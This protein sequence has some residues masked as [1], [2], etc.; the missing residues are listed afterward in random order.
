MFAQHYTSYKK[1]GKSQ[2]QKSMDASHGQLAPL[3][4]LFSYTSYKKAGKSQL[5]KSMDTSHGQEAA[6]GCSSVT[7]LSGSSGTFSSL[8]YPS[9]YEDNKICAW[10][11]T[12]PDNK[13]IHLW[14]VEFQT[15]SSNLCTEDR[16]TVED[17]VGVLG[18]FCGHTLPRPLVSVGNRLFVT[19]TSNDKTSDKGFQ[20]KYEAV[21]PS[22]IPDIVGGGGILEGNTGQFQSP[23]TFRSNDV[24]SNNDIFYQWKITVN[25]GYRV[26]LSFTRFDLAP[27]GAT[28]CT[29]MIEVF[30]GEQKGSQKLGHLCGTQIPDPVVSSGNTMIVRYWPNPQGTRGVFHATYVGFQGSV[31]P[32][33]S[34][35]TSTTTNT[36][37]TTTSPPYIDSGC[38]SNAIQ[39]GRKG[40]IQSLNHPDSYPANLHCSWNI[41][42]TT[43]RLIRLTFTEFAVD[44]ELGSCID[45]VEMSDSVD[46]I[47]T[48]CGF[49]N[50]PQL[51]T[52]NNKL[53]LSFS[54]DAVR[55]ESGFSAKWE[56]VY[57]N[58]IEEILSC[59]GGSNEEIGVLRTP[60]WP[61]SYG[62]NTMC[63]WHLQV[64]QGKKVTITFTHFDLEDPDLTSKDCYDYVAAYEEISGKVTKYGPY[65]GTQKP[66]AITSQGNI[67]TIRFYSDLFT[68]GKGFRAYWSTDPLQ[69]PPTDPPPEP[70]P[71]DS[72]VI[73]YPS[74]CGKPTHPPQI[75][76]RI[77]N[78]EPAAPHTWPWQVSMQVWPSSRN[79]TIFFHTCGGT[80]IHKNWVLTA[81]HCFINYADELYRWQMCL[82]KHNLTIEEPTEKCYKIL[83]IYRHEGFVYPEIPALEFDIALVRLD[84]EVAASDVIDFA[85]LPP[86]NQVLDESYRCH[87]TGW[88]DE[89][90]DSLAP[91]AA[92]TLNQ[93][94]LP[95]ISYE[96]CKTPAY[97]WFQIKDSMICAGYVAPDELKSVCQGDSGGPLVCPSTT[98][99]TV[100]E[101]H[102]ITSFGPIGCIMDKKPSVFTRA[103]A[104]LDWIDQIMKKD[105]YDNYSSGCG[106]AKDLTDR[107]GTFT[108]MRFPSTYKNDASC[109]WNIVAPSDKVIHLHFSG[110]LLE[111][112]TLCMNDKVVISDD[113]SSLGTHCGGAL[114][115][116]LVSHSNT[117]SVTFASNARVVDTGFAATWEF[118]EPDAISGI[119][120]CGGNFNSDNGEFMSPNW[121]NGTYPASKACT[122]KI[123]AQPGKQIHIVFKNFQLQIANLLGRCQDYVEIFNGDQKEAESLGQFC[124]RTIPGIVNTT[125]NAA[126]IRFISNSQQEQSGFYGYWTTDPTNI[127]YA[128]LTQP[129]PW[130]NIKIDMP[131]NC[132][133]Q[134]TPSL[135]NNLPL[136]SVWHVSVQSQTKSFMPFQHRCGGSLI[137]SQ[138]VLLPAHCMDIDQKLESW[139][140]CF[141]SDSAERCIGADALFTH[142]DYIYPQGNDHSNDIALLHLSEK[143]TNVQ[144]MCLPTSEELPPSGEFCYWA[145][146]TATGGINSAAYK[147]KFQTAVPI[148]SHE[149]CAQPKFWESHLTTSML[150]T[151]FDSPEKLK[152][153]CR[154]DTEGALI[155]KST[156]DAAWNLQGISSFGPKNCLVDRKPQ[157]FTR[158]STYRE[159]IEDQIKKYTYENI[160]T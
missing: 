86:H 148:M 65:C 134:S 70:N 59:G 150:C 39:V 152:S 54:S 131:T 144:P 158:V 34:P 77:V 153:N 51:V 125:G 64:P 13:V 27:A 83:G 2:L 91:K 104:H 80:L 88:G 66:N 78:G 89:T 122:W 1:A 140:V 154:S 24:R 85:C 47:G 129:K 157:V 92:E 113:I 11:I 120:S 115:A 136:S 56:E 130:D 62:P 109:I 52:A 137:N 57:P 133:K 6:T 141:E 147:T 12:V 100:W 35:T 159:W 81:A 53:F 41:S 114:P 79:E 36:A 32:T 58:D 102:G 72:V 29:E 75:K 97:W 22:R 116:D 10:D 76:S 128:P 63:L 132:D 48:Y 4:F 87:A 61:Y 101:V 105:I 119:A 68:E 138:W 156:S 60:K 117:L 15:E 43:G 33:D 94:A 151:G 20:A 16:L 73:D 121:P 69:T 55:T 124:G 17:N 145:G 99:S 149:I 93:V 42:V 19:F 106:N 8:N 112:S 23:S 103:S 3:Y 135:T 49:M 146:W 142:E 5:Q 160:I 107:K 118:V 139:R 37:S 84:G 25:S 31:I 9:K 21:D 155:C 108:S 123:N 40:V 71:W 82:G 28:G 74:T 14:F 96:V 95:V 26:K 30:D 110:F 7:H 50:P 18:T 126:V 143:V 98:D 38:G 111:D 46:F 44:G 45:N 90:G 127:T 67:V